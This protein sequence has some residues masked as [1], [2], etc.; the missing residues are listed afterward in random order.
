MNFTRIP[1][2]GD[3]TKVIIRVSYRPLMPPSISIMQ[4]LLSTAD[5]MVL[6]SI[7]ANT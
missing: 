4:Y 6:A 7:V 1:F 5:K 2:A 3:N